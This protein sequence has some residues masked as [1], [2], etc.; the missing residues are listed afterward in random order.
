MD[1]SLK[2]SV[3]KIQPTDSLSDIVEFVKKASSDKI[4]LVFP[5]GNDVLTSK[6]GLKT[7]VTKALE[8]KKAVVASVPATQYEQLFNEV[9]IPVVVR[10]EVAEVPL[11]LWEQAYKKVKEFEIQRIYGNKQ[12][13]PVVPKLKNVPVEKRGNIIRSLPSRFR[14]SQED[15]KGRKV[16]PFV[17]LFVLSLV[18]MLVSIASVFFVYYRFFPRLY[19]TVYFKVMPIKSK[20]KIIGT[21]AVSGMSIEQKKIGIFKQKFDVSEAIIKQTEAEQEKGEYATGVIRVFNNS[22]SN[23][24]TLPVGTVFKTDDGKSYVLSSEVTI[25][26]K[27][28]RD[29]SVKAVEYGE[30]YNISANTNLTVYLPGETS[31]LN[32][33]LASTYTEITGGSKTTVKVVTQDIVDKAKEDLLKTIRNNV[34]EQVSDYEKV[35]NVK[36]IESSLDIKIEEEQITPN[37]GEAADEFTL[38]LNVTASAYFYR[39]NVLEEL[40]RQLLIA[41]NKQ[42]VDQFMVSDFSYKIVN[43]SFNKEKAQVV[44]DVEYEG[45]LAPNISEDNIMQ[46]IKKVKEY[47]R[48]Q[49]VL[50]EEYKGIITKADIEFIPEWLPEFLRYIPREENRITINIEKIQTK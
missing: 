23:A 13:T 10:K 6:V 1:S 31:P 33:V 50:T 39:L 8:A 46:T 21:T 25:L 18:I 11:E 29:V 34:L 47:S 17:G 20:D 9:G 16:F 15:V 48:L 37:V 5:V 14:V 40:L 43:E 24:V 45:I 19:I 38:V 41:G 2:I 35:N 28:S 7:L 32:D 3:I 42:T 4:F 12:E 44:L 26:P 27:T 36:F 22:D 30:Q 49:S